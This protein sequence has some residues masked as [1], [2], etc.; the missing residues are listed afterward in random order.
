MGNLRQLDKGNSCKE[1]KMSKIMKK[2]FSTVLLGTV[3][4][5]YSSA[6]DVVSATQTLHTIGA[7]FHQAVHATKP[8]NSVTCPMGVK[9]TLAL[10]NTI[11]EERIQGEISTFANDRQISANAAHLNN[12]L[13]YHSSPYIP[14]FKQDKRIFDF[15]NGVYALLSDTLTLNSVYEAE[16]KAMGS[17]LMSLDFSNSDEAAGT[18]NGIVA[19]DT[20]GK[21]TQILSP[22][23]ISSDMVFVLLHTLYINASWIYEAKESILS[24]K[25]MEDKEKYVKSMKLEAQ[26]LRFLQNQDVTI[27]SVPTVGDC[28]LVIRHNSKNV[29]DLRPLTETEISQV[30]MT[31]EAYVKSFN[32][33]YLSMK[34]NHNLKSLLASDL[35]QILRGNF[36]TKLTNDPVIVS[37]YIQ[38]VTFDMTNKG[39]EASA[40]TVM[41]CTRESCRMTK[42]KDGPIIEINSPFTFALT[43]SI[44]NTPYLLFQGQVI[45]QD[46][47][48]SLE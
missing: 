3:S 5:S 12:L 45:N 25:N 6:M 9:Q 30:T 8:L 34:T 48:K 32:A 31:S 33:P 37:D 27:V 13:Q 38:M 15:S 40:A 2:I 20:R 43:K 28:Q 11:A 24:F 29:K 4:L 14:K 44:N 16:F 42:Q 36:Q 35:P 39:V 46:V 1:D 22:E 10:L 23:A 47:M 18:I 21:I 17:R 7:K 41:A 26:R 19:E